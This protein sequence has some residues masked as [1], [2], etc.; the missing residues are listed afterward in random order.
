GRRLPGGP[1]VLVDAEAAGLLQ[2]VLGA[3]S[4][5][6]QVL[7]GHQVGVD[8]VVAEGGVL[9]GAGHAGQ[10]E[11][12]VAVVV[13]ERDPQPG[14]GDED[15]EAE[16]GFEL[17]VVGGVHIADDGVGDVGADVEGGGAGRPVPRALL[18]GDG[19]PG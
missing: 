14:R 15:L 9:V 8:V 6:Q 18:A 11:A 12:A 16:A 7:A 5:G 1:L 4:G 17:L 10:A 19:P 13:T 3:G 2:V